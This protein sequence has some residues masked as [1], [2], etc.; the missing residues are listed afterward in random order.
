MA[1]Y[2]VAAL[3]ESDIT[4]SGGLSLDG[5]N[6]ADGSHLL[7]AFITLG[8]GEFTSLSLSDAT[9]DSNF[10]DKDG[11]QVLN[12]TQTFDGVTYADGTRIDAEY[13]LFL[14]DP[15][16]GEVYHAIG[17]NLHNSSPFFGTVEGLAFVDR[18]PPRG[19]ALEVISSSEGPG[20]S[21]Q[22]PIHS[23]EFVVCFTSGTHIKTD[24]GEGLIN[25]L[26]VGSEVLNFDSERISIRWIATRK[27]DKARLSK[28]PKLYPV[29]ISAGSLGNGLPTRDLLVS[30][31]HRMLVQ[32]KIAERMFGETEVLIPAIRLTDFPGIYVDESVDEVE[33]IHLLF[34]DHEVIFAEG[35]P[36]ESLFTGP[37]A[38][39]ALSREAR[40]EILEIF[41][42][43]ARFDYKPIPARK[44]P[45]GK[46]QKKLVERHVKNGK[47][48]LSPE[49]A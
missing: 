31:Q 38:L 9:T 29:R 15:A 40:R 17:F 26:Q 23:S 14:R 49:L 35:A 44:V 12:G 5:N 2:S 42:D 25:D 46:K 24:Q 33:Y 36:S 20:N 28:N 39:K 19:V 7:G 22:E 11:N 18:A 8:T 16:T 34:N 1:D 48:L 6:V 3:A 13:Q 43:I 41:P 4:I 45:P 32:S 37:Q 10:D 21:G 47:P 30:R 27:Y